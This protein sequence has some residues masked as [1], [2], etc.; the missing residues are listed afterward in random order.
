MSPWILCLGLLAAPCEKPDIGRSQGPA[1]VTPRHDAWIAEDKLRHFGLS[2]A[3]TAFAYAGARPALD[4]DAAFVV[5]GSTALMAGIAKELHD[6][7]AGG[8]FSLKDLAWD[9]AGVAL[10]LTLVYHIR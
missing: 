10:G 7:R 6:S 3:A 9:A 1:P 8:W 5:A 4:A 2:F